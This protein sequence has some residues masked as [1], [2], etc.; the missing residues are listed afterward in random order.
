MEKTFDPEVAKDISRVDSVT[1][2]TIEKLTD[3]D[4]AANR[5]FYGNSIT[6]SYRLKSELVSKC[7]QE[8]GMGR[9]QY[10]LFVVTG[11]GWITD[12]FWSQGIGTIQPAVR[13]EFADVTRVSFSSIA[14]YVGLIFGASFWGISADFVSTNSLASLGVTSNAIMTRRKLWDLLY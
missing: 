1:T 12:N 4:D 2:G 8:I 5:D 13:L 11:F 7:M 3:A 10:E 6:D 14:Y 9:Y